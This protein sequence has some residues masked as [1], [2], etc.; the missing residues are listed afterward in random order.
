MNNIFALSTQQTTMLEDIW[1]YFYNL[2]MGLD[3][4]YEHLG[5]DKSPLV[6]L[7]LVIL[8][9]FVGAAIACISM[10][11]NKRVIGGF[12]RALISNGCNSPENAK[13]LNELGCKNNFFIRNA[14]RGA[15]A[16]RGIV[17]TAGD[18]DFY[19]E[20]AR[21]REEYEE[22]RK[23]N[24]SLPK[25]KS[26]EYLVDPSTDRFYIPE[27]VRIKAEIKFEKKGAGWIASII[28]I[29]VLLVVFVLL[30]LVLPFLLDGLN[31]MVGG[32]NGFI[33]GIGNFNKS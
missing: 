26:R 33:S 3:T 5:F 22:R 14:V 28:A 15:E 8:G 12:V 11:Y 9:I 27:E 25:Y 13:T 16:L 30:L 29:A 6:S 21:R 24:K 1:N 19:A 23:M 18:A 31:D 32:I 4:G 7:R 10:A 20:E 2:F 17:R